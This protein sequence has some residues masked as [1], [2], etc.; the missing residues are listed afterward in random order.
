MAGLYSSLRITGKSLKDQTIIFLG[1]GEAGIGIADLIVSA[2]VEEGADEKEAR[3]HCWFLDSQGLVVKSRDNLAPH[4]LAYAHDHKPLPDLLAVV[5][6]LKPTA[7]IGVSGTPKK[8]TQP[9]VEAMAEFN[10]RPI[11]F[12][13]SNPTS[14]SECTAEEAYKWSNGRAIFASGSPFDPVTLDGKTT[15]RSIR[16]MGN[17]EMIRGRAAQAALNMLRRRL[18]GRED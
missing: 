1:A 18:L 13:L 15:S 2:M 11:I 6:E 14:K 9:I 17:R 5:K 16:T 12:A 4:K 8:F 7:L 10:E 3:R